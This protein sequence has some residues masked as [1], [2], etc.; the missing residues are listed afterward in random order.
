MLLKLE[1]ITKFYY[2]S[3]NVTMA[4][5]KINL[6]FDD[7]GFVAITGESGSGKS[8]LISI[9][10]GML[11][12]EEGELY[13]DGQPMSVCDDASWEKYRK[14]KIGF[15][16]QEYNLIDE[17][18][19]LDNVES[20]IIIRGL[21]SEGIKEYARELIKQVGLEGFERQRASKLSS[22][23]K[24]RLAIARALAKE[25]D[26]I[27]AD[28]PTGNLDSENGEMIM[29]LFAKIAREKLVIMVT[30]N[31]D[32]VE[33]Y[34]TRKI[35]LFD[36]KIVSDELVRQIDSVVG[37][38]DKIHKEVQKSNATVAMK[39]TILNLIKQPSRALLI[40]GFVLITAIISLI[41][42]GQIVS[43]YDDIY[44]RIYDEGVFAY[45]NDKRIVVKK[46]DG[47]AMLPEDYQFFKN[48]KYVETVENYDLCNDIRYCNIPGEDYYV[49]YYDSGKVSNLIM[50]GI[51]VN[52]GRDISINYEAKP[53]YMRSSSCITEADLAE[54]R[55]PKDRDEIVMYI[56]NGLEDAKEQKIF[57]VNENV[58]GKDY[59]G[60]DFKVVGILKEK[61]TQVFFSESFCDMI[62]AAHKQGDMQLV[63]A[64]CA[65]TKNYGYSG[66]FTPM[67]DQE[68]EGRQIQLSKYFMPMV[69]ECTGMEHRDCI[70][71]SKENCIANISVKKLLND[72]T[73]EA[74]EYENIKI[75]PS[76]DKIP[77]TFA[78]V[79]QE[80]FYELYEYGSHQASLYIEHYAYTD[81][82]I[83]CLEEE[84][85]DAI[86]SFRA[87]SIKHDS[88]KFDNRVILLLLS[89]A[90]LVVVAV[91]EVFIV[92]LFFKL[93]RKFYSILRF[94]GMA[95][96]NIK[97]INFIEINLYAIVAVMLTMIGA[98]LVDVSGLVLWVREFRVYMDITHYVIYVAYNFILAQFVAMIFNRYLDRKVFLKN[99]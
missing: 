95:S 97:R 80:Y 15:V 25:T 18:S 77:R 71:F 27:V 55:L 52:T 85:Y 59:Y 89:F 51:S 30:H 75:G 13:V 53:K 91:L 67:I 19:V 57:F 88:K 39:Y 31:Y 50:G 94:M 14:D 54:G 32:Q 42:I 62:T 2:S 4:L 28:E 68:L 79:S 16:F 86:S 21:R 66:V 40:G 11:P 38:K 44:T 26:I 48:I 99:R 78:N 33:P 72:G 29:E 34:V 10:S 93:R 41:F 82:V 90:I 81:E 20:A 36:G 87:S 58:W 12:F 7:R 49:G 69:R 84:G 1:N 45:E 35:R 64:W 61:T 22:G 37:R 3:T 83:T 46:P 43:N 6:D 60:Y 65:V 76:T 92:S 73:T 17:Y 23:Q 5:Q 24:Q 56:D 74:K 63:G 70:I 47:S 96:A 9:L 98:W 8:T